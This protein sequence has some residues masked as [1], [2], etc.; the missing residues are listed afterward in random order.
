MKKRG[1][2]VERSFAHCYETGAMRRVYLRGRENVWK[3]QLI[4]VGAFNLSL[5]FRQKLGAGTPR[6]LANRSSLLIFVILCFRM[7]FSM[8]PRLLKTAPEFSS[9]ASTRSPLFPHTFCRRRIS[10][11]FATG[12]YDEAMKFCLKIFRLR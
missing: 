5:V 7:S 6:E 9:A 11:G 1:E 8:A 2:L 3:R 10:E 12:C 4:H